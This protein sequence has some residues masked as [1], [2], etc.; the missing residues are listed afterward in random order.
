MAWS[1]PLSFLYLACF[2]VITSVV[3]ICVCWVLMAYENST[4]YLLAKLPHTCL[5]R[6][7]GGGNI[8]IMQ[9]K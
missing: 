3:F 6:E 8:V 1:I 7:E 4:T 2:V 5:Y 9:S